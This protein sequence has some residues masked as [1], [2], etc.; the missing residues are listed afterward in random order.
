[1]S[2]SP[3]YDRNTS[4]VTQQQSTRG[5]RR[6]TFERRRTLHKRGETARAWKRVDGDYSFGESIGKAEKE[7]REILA[8]TSKERERERVG[9]PMLSE[10]Y[11]GRKERGGSRWWAMRRAGYASVVRAFRHVSLPRI[12]VVRVVRHGDEPSW[13]LH[14]SYEIRRTRRNLSGLNVFTKANE[15][16]YRCCSNESM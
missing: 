16:V 4:R 11:K 5:V 8:W 13:R 10:F 9:R 12:F 6:P 15:Y 2:L 7:Q 14:F 3:E 1:M